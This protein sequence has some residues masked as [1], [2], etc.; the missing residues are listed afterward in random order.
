MEDQQLPTWNGSPL[1]RGPF[2]LMVN[3]D[4]RH[5]YVRELV[6]DHVIRVPFVATAD[7]LADFFTKGLAPPQFFK[8]RR[9][10]MNLPD[11]SNGEDPRALHCRVRSTGGC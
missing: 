5:F 7:N 9:I 1:A 10:I 11:D 8:L 6:E 4:R 3:I 2:W